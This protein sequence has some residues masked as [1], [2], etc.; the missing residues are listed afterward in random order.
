[1][2]LCILHTSECECDSVPSALH[3]TL[4]TAT[5]YLVIV[6]I[7]EPNG[8]YIAIRREYVVLGSWCGSEEA[9]QASHA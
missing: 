4:D 1:V 5:A 9:H 6:H 3:G 7:A 2:Y 8:I